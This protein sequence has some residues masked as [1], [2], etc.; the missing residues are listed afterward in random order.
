MIDLLPFQRKFKRRAFAPKTRIAC[1]TLPRGNG[2]STLAASFLTECLTPENDLFQAGAEYVLCASSI[3]QAR[4]VFRPVRAELEDK[5]PGEYRFTDS[6]RSLGIVHSA[7]KTRLV[8]QSSKAKTAMGLVNVP[9]VVADEPGAWE[10]NNGQ[11]MA[12]AILTAQGKP[13]STMR[14]IFIGTLAPAKSGWWHDL[15]ADGSSD[16]IHVQVLS[17]RAKRWNDWREIKRVNPL[18]VTYPESRKQLRLEL[19][20]ATRDSRLKARFLSYRLN[21]PTA[22]ES[23]LLLTL[24]DW[25][26]TLD[27]PV[28]AAEDAPVVGIDMGA[29]RAWSAAVAV[30]PN[31]RVEAIASAPGKPSL[32]DQEKRDRVPSGMYSGLLNTGRLMVAAGKR[33][34]PISELLDAVTDLWG[35]PSK[36]VCDRFRAAELEDYAPCEVVPRVT[37]WSD[38]AEDIRTLR[39]WALDGPLTV[40][41]TS[42]KL[43]T[44]S[45]LVAAVQND[46]QGN[47]RLV[48]QSQNNTARDDVAAAMLLAVGEMERQ[49]NTPQIPFQLHRVA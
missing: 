48:K 15:I 32:S 29:G 8:V 20:Q 26:R 17:G 45:L 24:D 2:K 13:D 41:R 36:I 11:L 47:C 3:E 5:F 10:V 4:H 37:R 19:K 1:L 18:M 28:P 14:A 9:L 38:A 12:D 7:T 25:E 34:Q 21:L 35:A 23:E 16:H 40:E 31:G 39:K 27:R 49:L 43:I 30:W 46:D 33:V 42:R 44:A 22:D 6:Q